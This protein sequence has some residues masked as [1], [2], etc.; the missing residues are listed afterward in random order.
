[1]RTG[2]VEPVD[3]RLRVRLVRANRTDIV[4]LAVVV[5]RDDLINRPVAALSIP[6]L[7]PQSERDRSAPR[8]YQSTPCSDTARPNGCYTDDRPSDR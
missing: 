2:V 5:P 1:M 8:P 4:R 6:F 3:P 7:Y